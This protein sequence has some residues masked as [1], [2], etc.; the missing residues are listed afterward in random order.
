MSCRISAIIGRGI[1]ASTIVTHNFLT[2][3]A[4]VA[5]T[6]STRTT[7]TTTASTSTTITT[8]PTTTADVILAI[9][10]NFEYLFWPHL[11]LLRDFHIKTFQY[12]SARSLRSR[13]N[14]RRVGL[15]FRGWKDRL[16]TVLRQLRY[17]VQKHFLIVQ[18]DPLIMDSH[19]EKNMEREMDFLHIG[20]QRESIKGPL[21]RVWGFRAPMSR[22][23]G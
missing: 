2:A 16:L 14:F 20:L 4:A 21:I 8:A 17:Y 7:I 13:A 23:R 9:V 5:I 3:A 10:L 11:W 15:G 19:M 18:V 12:P 6:T 22:H 1:F